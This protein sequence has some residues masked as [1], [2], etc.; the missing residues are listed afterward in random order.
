VS[1]C[2]PAAKNRRQRQ[3]QLTGQ[4][5]DGFVIRIDQ[6][7][8]RFG[9]LPFGETVTHRP[10][11]AANPVSHF[12]HCDLCTGLLQLDGGREARKPGARDNDG[13]TAQEA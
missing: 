8:A 4:S 7:S 1:E 6:I 12:Q 13:P 9:M 5:T 2:K 11:A 3:P 10:D